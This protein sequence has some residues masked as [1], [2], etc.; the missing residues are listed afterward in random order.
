M[1]EEQNKFLLSVSELI[2]FCRDNNITVTGGELWRPQE[3]QDLYYQQG[4]SKVKH[5]K[6]QDRLAIDLNFFSGK[7][8]LLTK[9]KL[10]FIGDYWESLDEKNIWGGNFPERYKTSFVDCPHFERQA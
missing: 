7:D 1:V 4:K 8:I 9:E 6:H 5:S 2:R 3:M 10:Q